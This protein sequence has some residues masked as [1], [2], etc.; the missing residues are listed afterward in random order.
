MD[1]IFQLKN[2]AFDA[3]SIEELHE[4]VKKFFTKDG[5]SADV[6]IAGDVV[7]VHFTQ[8]EIE[9]DQ[10][11]IQKAR[12]LCDQHK[13]NDARK[14]LETFLKKH[15]FHSEGYRLLAQITRQE[16]DSEK[17]LDICLES[18]KCD[19]K[20]IGDSCLWAIFLTKI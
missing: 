11:N 18:L 5:F 3:K 14:I 1:I 15:P 19:P 6:K 10:K 20:N 16:G 13:F 8:H 17:A 2:N 9:Q 4:K 12:D 7:L